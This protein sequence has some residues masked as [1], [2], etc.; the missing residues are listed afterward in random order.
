MAAKALN[1]DWPPFLD[2][3]KSLTLERVAIVAI[4][5]FIQCYDFVTTAAEMSGPANSQSWPVRLRVTD[6]NKRPKKRRKRR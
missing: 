2:N 4:L 5:Q 1:D 3:E 6:V